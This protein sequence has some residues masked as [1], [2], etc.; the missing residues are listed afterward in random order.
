MS[1]I[2]KYIVDSRGSFWKDH[3]HYTAGMEVELTE[4]EASQLETHLVRT[5]HSDAFQKRLNQLTNENESLMAEN[6][7]LRAKLKELEKVI[8]ALDEKPKTEKKK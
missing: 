8:S 4:E 6:A 5:N 7:E 3:V 2:K 1:G